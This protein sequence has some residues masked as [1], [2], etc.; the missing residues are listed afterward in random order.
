MRLRCQR[1]A[2]TLIELLVVIA[3]IA[4]I[5]GLLLPAVQQIRVIAARMQCQNNMKQIAIATHSYHDVKRELPYAV[6]DR[7]RGETSD[8]W[9]PG[10][11]LILPYL[12]QDNVAKRWDPTL[13]RNSTVDRNGDGFTNAMLQQMLIPT[14]VCPAMEPPSGPLPENRAYCS[15]LFNAG[16]PDVA[17]LHYAVH[18]GVPEPRYDG[19]IVPRRS[20]ENPA[21]A[22]SANINQKTH[23]SRIPDGTAHTFL[24]GETDFR[25]Q[26]VSSTS[27]GGV[28]AYG[29]IGY[30]WGTTFHP[31]NKHNNTTTVYGAFRSEHPQGGNFAMV[32]G[33]VHYI[34]Q[35]ISHNLYRA[36]STRAGREQASL[37][38]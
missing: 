28:W 14:Y 29:Y 26:G 23:L 7:Q 9:V 34:H 2:F 21:N 38:F 32:D 36:L 35:S 37:E 10:L 25:P 6:L 15:Y 12:E 18:Y 3:I 1:P 20:P 17:M 22:G 31:F 13:P 11:I 16:T 4:I 5:M 33:S 30:T 19:P 27:M 8:T 24:L